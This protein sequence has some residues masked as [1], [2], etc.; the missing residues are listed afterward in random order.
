MR[1]VRLSIMRAYL[2]VLSVDLAKAVLLLHS[3]SRNIQ[4]HQTFLLAIKQMFWDLQRTNMIFLFSGGVQQTWEEAY[5]E[6]NVTRGIILD[7][8]VTTEERHSMKYEIVMIYLRSRRFV[9][10]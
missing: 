4:L 10:L 5:H 3:A 8:Y 2:R 9:N 1:A 6:R 7:K